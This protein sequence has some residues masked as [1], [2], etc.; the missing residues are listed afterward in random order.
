MNTFWINLWF[1]TA[2]LFPLEFLV[3]DPVYHLFVWHFQ[4]ILVQMLMNC[5]T[6]KPA[7]FLSI[8]FVTFDRS[9]SGAVLFPIWIIFVESDSIS[10]DL[11]L[12][13][14]AIVQFIRLWKFLMILHIFVFILQSP[15]GQLTIALAF[16][17]GT[18]PRCLQITKR[19][20]G[21][22]QIL[23]YFH[24]ISMIHWRYLVVES[25]WVYFHHIIIL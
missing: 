10:D 12:R 8:L 11:L 17:Q 9:L 16:H 23:L 18:P 22:S 4:P 20:V 2:N 21:C 1:E 5:Y 15:P 19:C 6:F 25:L 7:R 13:P 14:V 3:K 24:R